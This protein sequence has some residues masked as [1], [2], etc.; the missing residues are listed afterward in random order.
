MTT[1]RDES[2]SETSGKPAS[3]PDDSA[4]GPGEPT[5][6]GVRRKLEEMAADW[7]GP[8]PLPGESPAKRADAVVPEP[9]RRET[10]KTPR[11]EETQPSSAGQTGTSAKPPATGRRP[12]DLEETLVKPAPK[13]GSGSE[14]GQHAHAKQ[15]PTVGRNGPCPCGSGKKY[16]HCHGRGATTNPTPADTPVNVEPVPWR[17]ARIRVCSCGRRNPAENAYC[18]ECGKR[19]P[20]AA[21]L[22]CSH[23]G[24]SAPLTAKFC[25]HCGRGL[26]E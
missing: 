12:A 25:E 14:A 11:T 8:P 22:K 4:Q 19:L 15:R 10:R 6:E 5:G 7:Q 23:C 26:R 2:K 1:E 18:N 21:R 24:K 20:P 9:V 13:G 3:E 17:E 16:K